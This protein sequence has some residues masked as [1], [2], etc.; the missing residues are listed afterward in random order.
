VFV[1]FMVLLF[2]FLLNS[3]RV[4]LSLLILELLGFSIV[5]LL[6]VSFFGSA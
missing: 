1:I 6:V 3:R 4:L 5:Y 2:L